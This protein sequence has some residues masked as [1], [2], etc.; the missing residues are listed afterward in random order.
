[1]GRQSLQEI[2]LLLRTK[3]Q[4]DRVK[5]SVQNITPGELVKLARPVGV[6]LSEQD[7]FALLNHYSSAETVNRYTSDLPSFQPGFSWPKFRRNFWGQS[8]A[9]AMVQGWVPDNLPQA[10]KSR[11]LTHAQESLRLTLQGHAKSGSPG[12]RKLLRMLLGNAAGN[13]GMGLSKPVF[14][15]EMQALGGDLTEDESERL[16]EHSSDPVTQLVTFDRFAH[17]FMPQGWGEAQHKVANE[18]K[19]NR[20]H[21]EGK[22]GKSAGPGKRRAP[23]QKSSEAKVIEE[24][25]RWKLFQRCTNNPKQRAATQQWRLFVRDQGEELNLE[26]FERTLTK[27][28]VQFSKA[29]AKALFDTYDRDRDGKISIREFQQNLLPRDT[30]PELMSP[31]NTLFGDHAARHEAP[32]KMRGAIL[33]TNLAMSQQRG[34]PLPTLRQDISQITLH[35]LPTRKSPFNL[36]APENQSTMHEDFRPCGQLAE[37]ARSTY[38]QRKKMWMPAPATPHFLKSMRVGV[39]SPGDYLPSRID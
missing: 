8:P 15:R 39:P 26:V 29:G 6:A 31:N 11:S 36:V 7:A 27:L 30:E 24:Q 1:M 3:V 14:R 32:R 21:A 4:P 28:H 19:A 10:A 13:Y 35:T 33:E 25:L 18:R 23:S 38:P 16:F 2:E 17:N 37:A 5:Q 12:L 34:I 20:E 9:D 22:F